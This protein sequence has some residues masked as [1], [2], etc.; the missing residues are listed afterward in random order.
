MHGK[1]DE[2]HVCMTLCLK[3]PS[4]FLTV[5][6]Q[7]NSCHELFLFTSDKGGGKCFRRCLCLSV[8]KITQKTRAWIWM[9]CCVSTDVRTWTNW[10]TFEPDPDYSPDGMPEPGCFLR[11]RYTRN[12][13]S[14]KSDVLAAAASRGF[15][16]VLFNKPVSHRNTFVGSKC[17]PPSALPVSLLFI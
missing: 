17:V 10:L 14:G 2:L 13:R 12:F 4:L 8:S 5:S 1:S 3:L 6:D 9:K 16:M 11:Y 7:T 15:T